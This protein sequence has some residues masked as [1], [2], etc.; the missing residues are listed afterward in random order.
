MPPTA[1]AAAT[2]ADSPFPVVAVD[3]ADGATATRTTSDI[4][5]MDG[6]ADDTADDTHTCAVDAEDSHDFFCQTSAHV[7]EKK[8]LVRG[9]AL[10]NTQ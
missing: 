9:V 10:G 8:I 7:P 6:T 5:P 2:L 4:P 3:N 1:S